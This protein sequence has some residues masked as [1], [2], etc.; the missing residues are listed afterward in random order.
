M[1]MLLLL[2][3]LTGAFVFLCGK[4]IDVTV[5]NNRQVI[6]HVLETRGK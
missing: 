3:V 4:F 1:K 5:E 6:Q 2:A